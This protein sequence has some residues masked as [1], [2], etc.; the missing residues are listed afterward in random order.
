MAR[1]GSAV[2]FQ[3]AHVDDLI[4]H[5]LLD[6]HLVLRVDR[7]LD[8]VADGDL[9]MG[10]HRPA[11]GIGQRYLALAASLQFRQHRLVAAALLAQRRDLLGEVVRPRA[12]ARPSFLDIALVEPLRD[13][14]PAARPPRG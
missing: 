3:Q 4:G 5:G 13:S 9:R 7:D 6:D 12:A 1:A 11:V 8:V 2:C 10:G 14:R